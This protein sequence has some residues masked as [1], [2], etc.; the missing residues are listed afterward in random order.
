MCL[1]P[2]GRVRWSVR[3]GWKE[4]AAAGAPV[5][6]REGLVVVAVRE[7]VF[8]FDRSGRRAWSYAPAESGGSVEALLAAPEGGVYA[9]YGPADGS[10]ASVLRALGASGEERWSHRSESR[11]TLVSLVSGDRVLVSGAEHVL[12]DAQ[13][14][15]VWS[16]AFIG[17]ALPAPDG[18]VYF[19]GRTFQAVAADGSLLCERPLDLP[20]WSFCGDGGVAAGDDG[21]PFVSC[22]L[23]RSRF[24]LRRVGALETPPRRGGLGAAGAGCGRDR[25]RGGG[26]T[27]GA[28]PG[29]RGGVACPDRPAVP[30]RVLSGGAEPHGQ[31]AAAAG[32][33]TLIVGCARNRIYA[34]A[35]DGRVR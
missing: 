16:H 34:V 14:R 10:G 29:R 24:S 32:D 7:G 35:P 30:R 2:D 28:G 17:S 6:T 27:L 5:L 20:A 12:L 21:T 18:R 15:R 22:G 33:G 19:L 13:G 8:A 23:P 25:L 31:P 4:G 9:S 11:A 3:D 1:G 26:L